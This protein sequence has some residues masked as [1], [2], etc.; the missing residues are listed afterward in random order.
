[1][2]RTP[3]ARH[4]QVEH[5]PPRTGSP[6]SATPTPPPTRPPRATRATWEAAQAEAARHATSR[7][8]IP[9]GPPRR[10]HRPSPRPPRQPHVREDV[11]LAAARQFCDDRI[12]G[13][14]CAKLLAASYPAAAATRA[15]RRD[16]R[17]A[18]LRQPPGPHHRIPRCAR[19]RAAGPGR[20]CRRRGAIAALRARTLA[21]LSDLQKYHDKLTAELAA[22]T[23]PDPPASRETPSSWTACPGWPASWTTARPG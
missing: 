19:G 6:A 2:E 7:D 9:G 16:R 22:R 3:R 20:D 21:R 1:M 15:A 5:R 17:A 12:F 11:I 4:G 10:R 18:A 23:A 8:D 14:D 13:P